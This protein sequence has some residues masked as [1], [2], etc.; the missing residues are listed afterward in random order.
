MEEEEEEQIITLIKVV[1]ICNYRSLVL[2][3]MIFD[4]IDRECHFNG[5]KGSPRSYSGNSSIYIY[6]YIYI[7]CFFDL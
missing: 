2:V 5:G 7:Y 3:L 4:V 1:K 6:I